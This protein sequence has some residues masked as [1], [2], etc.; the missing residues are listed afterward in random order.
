MKIVIVWGGGGGRE[1]PTYYLSLFTLPISV[2]NRIERIQRNFLWGG[3]G[4]EFKHH[5][6]S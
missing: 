3:M 6:V 4:D 1:F 2:A 5:L